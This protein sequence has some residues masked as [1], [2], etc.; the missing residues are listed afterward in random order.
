MADQPPTTAHE[1]IKLILDAREAEHKKLYGPKEELRGYKGPNREEAWVEL[2]AGDVAECCATV[3]DP[4]EKVAALAGGT[5][6]L[7]PERAVTIRADD[8]YHLLDRSAAPRRGKKHESA[9]ES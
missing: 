6:A 5:K 7:H 8:L 2:P 1:R 9:P 4:D 3:S